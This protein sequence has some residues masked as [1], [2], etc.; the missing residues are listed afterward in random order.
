MKKSQF[1]Y[2]PNYFCLFLKLFSIKIVGRKNNNYKNP[3]RRHKRDYFEK[4]TITRGGRKGKYFKK[5]RHDMQ[6]YNTASDRAND[7]FSIFPI[8]LE[9][10]RQSEMLGWP[11]QLLLNFTKFKYLFC[12]NLDI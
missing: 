5:Y 10:T 11:L 8:D 7:P 12:V 3:S 4:F 6:V 2:Y 1:T 9:Y